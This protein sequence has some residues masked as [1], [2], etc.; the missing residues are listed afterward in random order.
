LHARPIVAGVVGDRGGGRPSA[1]G[2]PSGRAARH[3]NRQ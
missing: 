2:N 3:L 1:I